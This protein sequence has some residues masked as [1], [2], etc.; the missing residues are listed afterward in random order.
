MGS[1]KSV[2]L[3]CAFIYLYT[4]A[5]LPM[6]SYLAQGDIYC[7]KLSLNPEVKLYT[8][9]RVL[10]ALNMYLSQRLPYLILTFWCAVP[11]QAVSA[12]GLGFGLVYEPWVT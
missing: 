6:S 2:T 5:S 8:L 12:H 10:T 4:Y 11:Y 9:F 7:R 1:S 3:E